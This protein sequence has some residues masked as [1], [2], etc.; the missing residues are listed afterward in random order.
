VSV[1]RAGWLAYSSHD[2]H[3]PSDCKHRVTNGRMELERDLQLDDSTY[4]AFVEIDP[5]VRFID[6]DRSDKR[7]A[8][9]RRLYRVVHIV[10]SV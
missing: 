6:R 9:T 2:F 5:Q 10:R 7:R 4:P 8:V 1:H 3:R